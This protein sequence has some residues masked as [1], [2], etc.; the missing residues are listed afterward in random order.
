[1][2]YTYVVGVDREEIILL[3]ESN[4][5]EY[6]L[7]TLII[8]VKDIASFFNPVY[9]YNWRSYFPEEMTEVL[10][11]RGQE[12]MLTSYFSVKGSYLLPDGLYYGFEFRHFDTRQLDTSINPI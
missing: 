3:C 4:D 10:C 9:L 6:D 5:T 11:M 8:K 2:E 12:I 7:S 1:M